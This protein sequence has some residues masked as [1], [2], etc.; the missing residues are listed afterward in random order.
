MIFSVFPDDALQVS[1]HPLFR[2]L[3]TPSHK[4]LTTHLLIQILHSLAP[5][6]THAFP[7]IGIFPQIE[8]KQSHEN[9]DD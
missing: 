7:K 8:S 6:S 1:C 9:L 5:R 3:A 4:S 2:P